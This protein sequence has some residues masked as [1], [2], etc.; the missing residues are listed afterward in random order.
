MRTILIFIGSCAVLILNLALYI[1]FSCTALNILY[2]VSELDLENS[3]FYFDFSFYFDA[4]SL[5]LLL[6]T[7][8]IF[9]ISVY[10][11]LYNVKS[12]IFLFFNFNIFL[13]FLL[14]IIFCILDLFVFYILF[15]FVLLPLFFLISLWGNRL[16]R[17]R[18]ATLFYIYTSFFSFFLLFGLFIIYMWFGSYDYIFVKSFIEFYHYSDFHLKIIWLIFFFFFIV[19]LPLIPFHI[20]LPEAHVEAPTICSVILASLILK[21]GGYGLMRFLLPLSHS[22]MIY[23]SSLLLIMSVLSFLYSTFIALVQVDLKKIIAYSSISHMSLF[24]IGISLNS[25]YSFIGSWLML[26]AHGFVSGALFFLIGI[27]YV[28]F[29]TRL[30]KYFSGLSVFSDKINFFFFFSCLLILVFQVQL[31][32]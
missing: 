32:L 14:N 3:L 27:I 10:Y 8:L 23:F 13:I 22:L 30:L 21:L 25:Y 12:S 26:L 31:I 20:W 4:L 19:K 16:Q 9:V 11:S 24:L 28:R 7:N 15:E 18:A 6:L 1:H 29:N 5:T 2:C 17:L